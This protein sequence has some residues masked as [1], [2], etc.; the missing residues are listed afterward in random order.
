MIQLVFHIPDALDFP[1]SHKSHRSCKLYELNPFC[2]SC[3]N[4]YRICRHILP[5]AAVKDCHIIGT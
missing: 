5:P 2:Q 1:V 3:F 4:F